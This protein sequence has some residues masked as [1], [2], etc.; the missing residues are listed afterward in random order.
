MST[1][2]RRFLQTSLAATAATALTQL[3]LSATES[4]AHTS[5]ELYELR[6]YRL[7]EGASHALLDG[8]LEKTF[9]PAV[10]AQGVRAVGVFTEPEAKDGLAVWVLVPHGT[11]DVFVTLAATLNANPAIQKSAPEYL[12]QTTKE[13]PAFE[14][15][16]TWLLLAFTGLPRLQPPATTATKAPRI[17]ELRTYESF[18]E[19]KALK[20]VEMFNAGEIDVMKEVGLSPV[21]YGQALAG[22]DLPHLS[23]MTSGP[24]MAT[25]LEHWKAFGKHPVWLKL[26][27]DPYYADTVTKITKRFLIP[28]AYSQL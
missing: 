27:N 17:F 3:K 21:F 2:R 7:K 6:A 20:K 14:R 9:I 18:S 16:D 12:E 10:N 11:C 15:I 13:N 23:Y 1:S 22:R 24:D 4:P 26:K 28:T 19:L 25:H 8:Y 5:R